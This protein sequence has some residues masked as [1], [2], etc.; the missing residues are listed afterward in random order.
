MYYLRKAKAYIPDETL[1]DYDDDEMKIDIG[2]LTEE[3][4]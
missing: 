4:N 2:N 3:A 1:V